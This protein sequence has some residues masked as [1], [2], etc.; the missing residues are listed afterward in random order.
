[1]D[2]ELVRVRRV[3]DDEY[4][5]SG[6]SG[7]LIRCSSMKRRTL[8]LLDK[9][10]RRLEA[11]GHAG[12]AAALRCA[13]RLCADRRRRDEERSRAWRGKEEKVLGDHLARR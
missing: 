2:D 11:V 5:E 10:A 9:L 4:G 6:L 1:L 7:L 3:V 8:V 12:A 13:L